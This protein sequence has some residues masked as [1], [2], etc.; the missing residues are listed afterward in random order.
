[1]SD[2]KIM[3]I[4][5]AMS[6]KIYCQK[7][8]FLRCVDF[9]LR[10]LA[11]TVRIWCVP[12]NLGTCMAYPITKLF[13]SKLVSIVPLFGKWLLEFD[14]LLSCIVFNFIIFLLLNFFFLCYLQDLNIYY[15][16]RVTA[17]LSK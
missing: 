8:F 3:K 1:M 4:I 17:I 7:F 14:L 13:V 15:L 12:V 9:V 5:R 6:L 2:I 11:N 10:A 16:V